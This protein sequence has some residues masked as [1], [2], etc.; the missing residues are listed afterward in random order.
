[1]WTTGALT[2]DIEACGCETSPGIGSVA[3]LINFQ[4]VDKAATTVTNF[5]I[6][7]ISYSPGAAAFACNVLNTDE[8]EGNIKLIR[9]QYRDGWDQNFTVRLMVNDT[10]SRIRLDELLRSRVMVVYKL[11]T[12]TGSYFEVAG[13]ELGLEVLEID[14]NYNDADTSGGWVVS[15]GCNADFKEKHFPYIVGTAPGVVVIDATETQSVTAV[16]TEAAV[17]NGEITNVTATAVPVPVAAYIIDPAGVSNHYDVQ[18]VTNFIQ[19]I[20]IGEKLKV[21]TYKLKILFTQ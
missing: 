8:P 12:P 15:L 4:D 3:Y 17:I 10:A 2:D 18:R 9:G 21:G 14:R 13:W 1:M 11:F 5:A 7:A 20:N 19:K 6:S 16:I